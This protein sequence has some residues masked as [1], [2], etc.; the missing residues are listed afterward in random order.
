MTELANGAPAL[1]LE[2]IEAG[3]EDRT[4]LRGISARLEAGQSAALLGANGAGK[5]TLL[6][7]VLGLLEPWA[8]RVLVFGQPPRRL[9][10]RRWQIGYVPQLREVDRS[11]PATVFDVVLMGRVGRLGLARWPTAH[12]RALV[13]AALEQVG[14]ADLAS[15][16]FG[17]L[18]GGQQ[19]RVF[20]ARALAQ[21]PDLLVLDE[22]VAGVDA[23]SRARVGQLLAELQDRGTPLLVAT[24]DVDELEPFRFDQHWTIVGGKLVIDQPGDAHQPHAP[25]WH[26]ETSVRPPSVRRTGLFRF[27]RRASSW[28]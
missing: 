5:S 11:F 27:G 15:R 6:K 1:L 25:D 12:D 22:P 14:L 3:Y 16:P 10:H 21:E 24:H 7:V 13:T 20:L 18:S 19:Q 8:G 23:A 2:D 17:A 9:N 26:E 28:G 4:V